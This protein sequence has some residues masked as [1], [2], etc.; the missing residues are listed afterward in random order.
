MWSITLPL[1]GP[2]G[3]PVAWMLML[4]LNLDALAAL[5]TGR[6]ASQHQGQDK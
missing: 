3:D 4:E 1:Q 5:G 2:L 6:G